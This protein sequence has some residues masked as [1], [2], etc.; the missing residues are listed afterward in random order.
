[1]PPA[2]TADALACVHLAD[3]DGMILLVVLSH[4][5]AEPD[6]TML[7]TLAGIS[8]TVSCDVDAS[9]EGRRVWALVSTEPPGS[10]TPAA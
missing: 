3:Q 2:S 1:M 5:E 4:T 8:T 6:Q 7:T 9:D 10:R